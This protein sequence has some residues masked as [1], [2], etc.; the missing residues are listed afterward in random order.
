MNLKTCTLTSTILTIGGLLLMQP[1]H[2]D[3]KDPNSDAN[4]TYADAKFKY[5]SFI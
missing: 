1:H 4:N 5:K 3:A 2:A